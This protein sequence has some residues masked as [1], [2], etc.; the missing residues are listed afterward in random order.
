[1]VLHIGPE[2]FL[3]G[4]VELL[5]G[6]DFDSSGDVMCPAKLEHLLSFGDTGSRVA[7]TKRAAVSGW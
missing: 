5:D 2:Q 4:F 7:T 1:M 6:D 3:V